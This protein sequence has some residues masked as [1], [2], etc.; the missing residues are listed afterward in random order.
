MLLGLMH[1]LS[2]LGGIGFYL[3]AVAVVHWCASRR[4]GAA[5]AILLAVSSTVNV[6]LKVLLR[7]PRPFWI[8]PS[9]TGHE[10][11]D[12]FG[13]PSGHAQHAVVAW[14]L[15]AAHLRRPWAYA[16]AAAMVGLISTSRVAL[17][18]HSPGQ[19]LAGWVV[20][21]A[22]LAAHLIAGPAVARWWRAHRPAARLAVSTAVTAIL[23]AAGWAVV[24]T[25]R[26]WRMPRSWDA[27]ITAAGG[28]A[29]PAAAESVAMAT[30]LLFGVLAGLA[31]ASGHGGHGSHRAHGSNHAHRGTDGTDG[32]PRLLGRIAVGGAGAVVVLAA[33]TLAA[34]HPVILFVVFALLGA[35]AMAGAPRLFRRLDLGTAGDRVGSGDSTAGKPHRLRG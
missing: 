24:G 12:S 10:P 15:L 27:A 32:A 21:G 23:L 30:G 11:I 8:D 16:A 9:I 2:F 6:L 18:V 31:W 34:P 28:A 4:F 5:A 25:L 13:M 17:G 26:G 19:I 7:E 14:G 20:G 22:L 1:V 33:G 3:S 35:W 29:D